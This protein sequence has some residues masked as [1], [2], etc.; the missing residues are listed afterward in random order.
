M[1]GVLGLAAMPLR[2][3]AVLTPRQL[4]SRVGIGGR[5]RTW[6]FLTTQG[7]PKAGSARG[8]PSAWPRLSRSHISIRGSSHLALPPP[9]L[10][11]QVSE[12]HRILKTLACILPRHP[13]ESSPLPNPARHSFLEEED[14]R[15]LEALGHQVGPRIQQEGPP[16]PASK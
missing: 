9:A 15:G 4:W 8:T 3:S 1:R 16:H 12:L 11:T 6:P 2:Y 14:Q 7:T 5:I 10:L 13:L